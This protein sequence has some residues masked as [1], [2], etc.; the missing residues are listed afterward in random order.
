MNTL[1]STCLPLWKM[2]T[3][4]LLQMLP[5]QEELLLREFMWNE[6]SELPR[7]LIYL[8]TAYVTSIFPRGGGEFSLYVLWYRSLGHASS[9][10][11]LI[12]LAL[13]DCCKLFRLSHNRNLLFFFCDLHDFVNLHLQWLASL[14][15]HGPLW[16][17]EHLLYQKCHALQCWDQ[18]HSRMQQ[19]LCSLP[20]C[21]MNCFCPVAAWDHH[22]QQVFSLRVVLLLLERET[23][24]LDGGRPAVAGYSS[25]GLQHLLS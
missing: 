15:S 2:W 5:G 14:S 16:L 11:T 12:Q 17:V 3:S 23:F 8:V 18:C 22:V 10:N 7:I 6:L 9:E 19:W 25:P 13:D 4:C 20:P 24:L 21:S 1:L